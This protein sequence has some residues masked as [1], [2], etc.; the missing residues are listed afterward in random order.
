MTRVL[1]VGGGFVGRAIA[2]ALERA[3]GE[4]VLACRNRPARCPR[5]RAPAG[6]TKPV[7][8]DTAWQ[9]RQDAADVA[10]WV[11]LDATDAAGCAEV[12][13]E[14]KPDAVI[15]VHGPSDVTWCQRHPQAALEAHLTA[16]D[17][18][19][20]ATGTARLLMISTD[21]VFDGVA[22]LN[23]EESPTAPANAYGR[24]KLAA[25]TVVHSHPDATVL[26]VSLVYGPQTPTPGKR[27]N[28]AASCAR[29]LRAGR[30]V[31]APADQWTTPVHVG[32]VATVA[33]AAVREAPRLLH[34]GGPE[35]L[36]RADW[37]RRLADL[38]KAP[39]TLVTD[40]ARDAGPYACRPANSCLTSRL[41]P[42][43]L[44]T[45]GLS[46]R[47][48]DEGA[49]DLLEDCI[50]HAATMGGVDGSTPHGGDRPDHRRR[51][52]GGLHP[53]DPA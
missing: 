50:R 7:A 3:G 46:V 16:T 11:R 26:R 52:T 40:V 37:A 44:H 23:D 31:H 36:S 35:R 4:P 24:A 10:R 21:N 41:L 48:V 1:I 9:V 43:L 22:E 17:N 25:E 38:T 19:V 51:D 13:H 18:L 30:A 14:V 45:W 27:P 29:D 12:V 15:A 2:G 6:Q 33:L 28:F 53:A 42:D 5:V 49:A 8:M 32:D 47:G 39:R 20:R 34:L